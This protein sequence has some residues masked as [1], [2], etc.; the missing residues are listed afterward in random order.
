MTPNETFTALSR[1]Q[2]LPTTNFTW[3]PFSATAIYVTGSK[4]HRVYQLDL[5]TATV[6]IFQS[7]PRSELSEHFVP[8]KTITL[9]A[10]QLNQLP[11]SQPVAS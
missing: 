10:A 1:W 4:L 11:H 8:L 6:A 3:R 7:D 5:A 9:T 2:L